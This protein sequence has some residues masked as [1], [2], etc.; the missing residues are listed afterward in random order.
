MGLSIF[1]FSAC[2]VEAFDPEWGHGPLPA[3][4]YAPVANHFLNMVATPA[5]TL[6]KNQWQIKTE[7]VESNAIL[8]EETPEVNGVIKHETLRFSLNVNYGLTDRFQIGVEVPAFYRFDGFLNSFIES[9]EDAFA[10]LNPSRVKL[11]NNEFDYRIDLNGQRIIEGEE[12]DV[13][14][15]DLILNTRWV[16][17]KEGETRPAVALRLALK[18][19]TGDTAKSFGSGD[20]DVGLGL[21]VQKGFGKKWVWYSN[22]NGVFPTGD[23]MDTGLDLAPFFSGMLAMEY[24]PIP[25]FSILTQFEY[26]STPF[27][28]INSPILEDGVGEITAGISYLIRENFLF[29]MGGTENFTDP[30]PDGSSAD[31]SFFVTFGYQ[32]EREG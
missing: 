25:R 23:F 14:L 11:I 24:R 30:F 12:D 2:Q 29:Q 16:A 13:G 4:N 19:P 8:L 10:H 27:H 26:F 7:F 9:V 22:V 15:G 3:R 32:F 28:G 5:K 21:A 31:F 17:I 18:V 20:P 6:S 1:I